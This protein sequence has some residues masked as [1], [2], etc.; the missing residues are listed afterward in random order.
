MAKPPGTCIF[1][2]AR[3]L[4]K[5][6]ILPDWLKELLSKT[7]NIR[8]TFGV[9]GASIVTGIPK[10]ERHS[11]Q[12]HSGTVKVRVVCQA[13]NNGWLSVLEGHAKPILIS[14]IRGEKCRLGPDDLN[15]LS[16]WAAKTAMT[17]EY[18]QPRP[19]GTT[20]EERAFL[21][22]KKRPPPHW[23]V[24]VAAY[25]GTG[26][27]D[28]T[29]FQSRGNLRESPIHRSGAAVHYIQA[30]TFGMGHVI[31]HIIGTT[32]P[33]SE[34]VFRGRE[35]SGLIRV[36]PSYPRSVLWPPTTN[37]TDPQVGEVAHVLNRTFDNSLN[38]LARWSFSP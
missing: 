12:G 35:N 10:L 9:V 24:W 34:A 18:K 2:E 7:P 5:E 6:H 28:L 32:W 19:D 3:G 26:W 27:D 4:S 11:R 14:L 36:W 8:H 30:T 23:L 20:Q 31:F 15:I 13:C 37:L 17:A 1:C 29:L 22:Q 33:E 21:K 25:D 38:P 16:T